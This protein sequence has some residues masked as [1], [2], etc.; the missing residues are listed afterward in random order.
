[1]TELKYRK[2]QKRFKKK[3]KTRF[4]DYKICSEINQLEKKKKLEKYKL[5]QDSLTKNY[6]EH[7]KTIN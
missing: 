7:I 2:I 3:R 1:M 5:D 6:K 4:E